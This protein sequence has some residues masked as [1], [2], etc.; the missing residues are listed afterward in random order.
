[1]I[2]SLHFVMNVPPTEVALEIKETRI[3]CNTMAP[4]EAVPD[5]EL[6]LEKKLVT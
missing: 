2:F 3:I 1:M 5:R 4:L 6:N